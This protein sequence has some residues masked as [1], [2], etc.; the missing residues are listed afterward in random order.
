GVMVRGEIDEDKHWPLLALTLDHP[1]GRVVVEPVR[2]DAVGA[3]RVLIEKSLHPGGGLKISSAHESPERGI[4]REGSIPAATQRRRQAA[5][6]APGGDLRHVIGEA[7]ERP[8]G[9][10]GKHVILGVP[11]RTARTFADEV[12]A[13][14]VEGTE[15]VAVIGTDLDAGQDANVEARFVV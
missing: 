5:L 9:E 12:A 6:H 15:V 11:A 14:A 2:L 13:L 4:D 3:E 7:P 1:H 8:R 10:A